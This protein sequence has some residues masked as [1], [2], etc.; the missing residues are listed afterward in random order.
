MAT[1][2]R[3]YRSFTRRQLA[4]WYN[5]PKGTAALTPKG[6]ESMEIVIRI[7]EE[8]LVQIVIALLQLLLR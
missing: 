7:S 6:V 8:A 2:E 1:N 3:V 4:R 5:L